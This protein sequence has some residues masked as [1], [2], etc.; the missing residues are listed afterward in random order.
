MNLII[1]VAGKSTRFNSSRPKWMLTH[2]SGR[3]MVVEAILGLNLSDF[4]KIFFVAL[5]EHETNFHFSQGLLEELDSLGLKEKSEIVLLDR[6]T[7]CQPETV[8]E[9]IRLKSLTGSIFIKDSDN[10]FSYKAAPGN[11]VC[12]YS[13]N[14]TSIINP[15]NKSYITLDSNGYIT[16]IVEKNVVSAMFSVGGYGVESAEEFTKGFETLQLQLKAKGLTE[17]YI[18]DLM[19]KMLLEGASIKGSLVQGYLDWGTQEDWDRYKKDFVTLFLDLDGTL[20]ENSSSHFPPYT[21]TTVPIERNVEYLT[22]LKSTGK[23]CVVITTSRPEKFREATKNQLRA[24]NIPWD[25]LIMG[26]PHCRRIIVNDYAPSS[27]Y[28][29]CDSINLKRNSSELEE[30]LKGLI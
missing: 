18:S 22:R 30:L 13:L 4:D 19:F 17:F 8:A 21:A 27:T 3:F 1:P 29:M 2:P 24:N 25:H 9:L 10:Y 28:R 23:V 6:T 26:L 11:Q 20:V 14:Q 15:R 5:K 7:S 16:S 12:Y